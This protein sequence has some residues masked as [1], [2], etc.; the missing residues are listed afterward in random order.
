M[1]DLLRQLARH[2]SKED[3]FFRD[4]QFL[5]SKIVSKLRRLSLVTDKEMLVL[6]SVD[7][8]ELRVRTIIS[9]CDKSLTIE[10]SM[11]KRF[12]YVHVLDLSSSNVKEIPNYIGSLIHLRLFNLQGTSITCLPESIGSLKNLQVL[13]L[14]HCGYLHSLPLA[15][16]QL[17]NLRSLRLYNTPINQVPKG[18]AGLK[19]INDLGGFPIGGGNAV[20]ARMQDGWNLEEL[21]P[22]MQLRRLHLINL[23][24]AGPCSTDSLLINKRYLKRLSLLCTESRDK[25]Y[26]ED[27]LINIQNTFDL[28]IPGHNLEDL[29]FM[30]FIGRWFPTWLDINSA[31]HL[32]SLKHL[33]LID[34]KSCMHLP[35]IGQLPNLKYLKISG[36]TAVTRIGPEFVGSRSSNLRS[37]EA[38]AFP[39]LEILV[40]RNMPNWEEWSFVVEEEREATTAVKEGGEDGA[41]AKQKGE[42]WPPRM[43]LLPRLKKLVLNCCPKLRALPPQLGQE[44]TS[45]KELLLRRVHSLKVVENLYFLSE[46]LAITNCERLER[47]SNLPQVRL[48]RLQRCPNLWCVDSMDNLR[49]LFLTEDMQGVCSSHWLPGLQEQQR[50]LHGEDM[51]VYTWT[52]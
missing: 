47:V 13:G 34:C 48:L 24:R 45:L 23:E 43:Q 4:P 38:V 44:A 31:T 46:A 25:P 7:N 20:S 6:P 36:A 10:P 16:T 52:D 22:L 32:P 42:V 51:D 19:S 21:V 28:L 12:L 35:P 18:I 27:A 14:Q 29:N 2:L 5:E 40:I 39:R 33:A 50:H 30:N 49:Q 17:C 41:A 3:C 15:V 11:F 26:S 37:I 8:Q 9:F 1:H